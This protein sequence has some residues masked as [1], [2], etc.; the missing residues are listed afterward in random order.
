[1]PI[2][3]VRCDTVYATTPKIPAAASRLATMPSADRAGGA[4]L[5]RGVGESDVLSSGRKSDDGE[6]RRE[7][8]IRCRTAAIMRSAARRAND[9]RRSRDAVPLERP[10]EQCPRRVTELARCVASHDADDFHSLTADAVEPHL[11]ADARGAVR[12]QPARQGLVHE[13]P[14]DPG[15]VRPAERPAG[16]DRHAQ[17]REVVRRHARNNRR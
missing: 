5:R 15:R 17:R 1:M 10:P 16:D 3:R 8:R 4:A 11:F 2:S 7:G 6:V 12:P 14:L 13:Y 9:D